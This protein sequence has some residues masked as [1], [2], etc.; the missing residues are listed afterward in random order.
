MSE[1][2]GL[3]KW[4]DRTLDRTFRLIEVDV[5]ITAAVADGTIEDHEEVICFIDAKLKGESV[6][7]PQDYSEKLSRALA[8]YANKDDMLADMFK[9]ALDSV[10]KCADSEALEVHKPFCTAMMQELLADVAEKYRRSKKSSDFLD[11]FASADDRGGYKNTGSENLSPQ[12]YCKGKCLIAEAQD[13][14]EESEVTCEEC[15]TKGTKAKLMKCSQCL[16]VFYCS[17]D[18]QKKDWKKNH[19]KVCKTLLDARREASTNDLDRAMS[20]NMP[21]IPWVGIALSGNL[22]GFGKEVVCH[23]APWLLNDKEERKLV[24]AETYSTSQVAECVEWFFR[25]YQASSKAASE[26]TT[27]DI[28][29]M[30]LDAVILFWRK[31][32]GVRQISIREG[33][34]GLDKFLHEFYLYSPIPE[35]WTLDSIYTDHLPPEAVAEMKAEIEKLRNDP[36]FQGNDEGEK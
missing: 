27:L 36:R 2:T 32:P 30:C 31:Y 20:K 23:V 18:C 5:E 16:S 25:Q 1:G 8:F 28:G 4:I 14:H 35:G 17:K 26:M 19:K 12:D 33:M 29:N 10:L 9:E 13:N 6:A 3:S 24:E 15:G 22:T 7:T 21:R 34:F 11:A